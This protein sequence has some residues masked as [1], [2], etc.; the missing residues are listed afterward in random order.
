MNRQSY[1]QGGLVLEIEQEK[2]EARIVWKGVSQ[3]RNPGQFLNPLVQEWA[4]KLNN[5]AVTV[6]LRQL[7]YMNSATVQPL[8]SLIKRLDASG[9]PIRVLFNDVDWQKTH[10]NCMSAIARTLRHVSV[11]G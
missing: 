5:V 8:V 9:M 6:D 7:E 2:T 3:E 4:A 11:N 10:R 1:A